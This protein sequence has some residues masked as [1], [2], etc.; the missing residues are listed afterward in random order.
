MF[1]HLGFHRP[2]FFPTE[3]INAEGWLR[4][5]YPFASMTTR[6]ERLKSLPEAAR[7]LKPGV[8]CEHFDAIAGVPRLSDRRG[9]GR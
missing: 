2:C 1:P 9:W 4:K 6:Y 8:T 5:H 3:A 7:Y